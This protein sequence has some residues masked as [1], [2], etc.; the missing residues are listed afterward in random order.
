M[1]KRPTDFFEAIAL[2]MEEHN[3]PFQCA[4]A[5]VASSKGTSNDSEEVQM[6]HAGH[7]TL[8][9]RQQDNTTIKSNMDSFG[10]YSKAFVFPLG[11]GLPGRVYCTGKPLWEFQLQDANTFARSEG[12][13]SYGIKSAMGLP[14]AT[15]GGLGRIVVVFYS[16]DTVVEDSSLVDLCIR[17]LSKY[18]PKP[19]WKLIVDV[20]KT[21]PTHQRQGG[22]TTTTTTSHFLCDDDIDHVN[23][24]KPGNINPDATLS[25]PHKISSYDDDQDLLFSIPPKKRKRNDISSTLSGGGAIIPPLTVSETSEDVCEQEIVALLGDQIAPIISAGQ[26]ASDEEARKLL[27]H[28]TMIRLL[29][30]RPVVRRSVQENVLIETLKSSYKAYSSGNQRSGADLAALLAKEW[31]LLKDSSVSLSS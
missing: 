27:S 8:V 28:I 19:N 26:S 17:E 13:K 30:L 22:T 2:C 18:R 20:A 9:K 14:I 24:S 11:S 1:M 21:A 16:C 15:Q 7:V 5:W 23:W 10:E 4:D 25:S 29:L 12:A 6:L 3:L 31:M